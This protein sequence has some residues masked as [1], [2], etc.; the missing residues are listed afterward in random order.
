[1][2]VWAWATWA[3]AQ[4]AEPVGAGEAD[5]PAEK[6]PLELTLAEALDRL[7]SDSPDYAIARS[8][9]EAARGAA[10][11]AAAAF[12]PIMAA[13]AGYTRNDAEVV[14]SFANLLAQLPI[15]GEIDAPSDV[16]IQPLEV[17]NVS[18]TVQVP[19]VAPSAWADAT[20]AGRGVDAAEWTLAEAE[21]QLESALV[22]A[23]AAAEAAEGVVSAAR[24]AV[25]VADAHRV[26]TEIAA[27]VGTATAVDVLA[28]R[29]DVA[30]RQSELAQAEASLDQSRESLGALL[31]IDGEVRVVLPN[32]AAP[33]LDGQQTDRPALDAAD[34]QVRSAEARVQ[35][36]WWRHVPTV[37]A[38]A[39]ALAATTPFPTG[40]DTAYKL[41][42]QA[43]WTL[44]DGG[45]RY[46]R[47]RQA[48]AEL[49]GAEATRT[50]E[51]L[52]VAREVRDAER[53][54]RVA[55]VQLALAQE[56]STLASEAAAVA[57]RG[58][59]AG[60]VSPLQARDTEANAFTAEV[61]VAGAR[62]RLRIAEAALRRAHGLDQRW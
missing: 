27:E 34:A 13:N 41:G 56:Q 50:S 53:S 46:G 32:E 52:R 26:S 33:E 37:S 44:Y 9:V 12:L 23:A 18:G 31:G 51:Q 3:G 47:L 22:S 1:M 20:A 62:A 21:L 57:Q 17:W 6:P 5:A 29:A 2:V 35:A 16:T 14:L 10:R 48:R 24:R 42:V 59:S 4:A 25:D 40:N 43:T 7:G 30:R 61:G 39:T 36:A 11:Q 8:R 15:P 45:F 54:Y 60:T 38:S 49:A 19:L 28:A 55:K 58:L